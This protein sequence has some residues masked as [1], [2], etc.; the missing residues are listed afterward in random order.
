MVQQIM[1]EQNKKVSY[2]LVSKDRASWAGYYSEFLEEYIEIDE[3]TRRHKVHVTDPEIVM[4]VKNMT[5]EERD[6]LARDFERLLGWERGDRPG[7]KFD[8]VEDE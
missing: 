1:V 2:R 3:T 8:I 6:K 5:L 4:M 7:V